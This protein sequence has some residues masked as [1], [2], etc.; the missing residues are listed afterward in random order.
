MTFDYNFKYKDYELRA[1]PKG[2]AKFFSED[3][4]ANE[5]IELVK[6]RFD[7]KEPYCFVIAYWTKDDEGYS[8][9]FV[10][11]RFIRNILEEDV[12]ILWKA[13]SSA[14]RVLDDWYVL[15]DEETFK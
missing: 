6:W 5:T 12:S 8:L 15:S 4:E 10:G 13:I 11:D 7:N 14:Q 3:E 9:Q 1:C 2:L